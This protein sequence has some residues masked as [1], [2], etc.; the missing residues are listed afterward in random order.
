MDCMI[1]LMKAN[2]MVL[3]ILLI[4]PTQKPRDVFVQ[5]PLAHQITFSL[6]PSS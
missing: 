6:L 2:Q 3:E 1:I 5:M 4:L